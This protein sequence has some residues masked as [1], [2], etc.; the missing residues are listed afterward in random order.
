MKIAFKLPRGFVENL[1]AL[2]PW[3]F[4]GPYCH[5]ELVFDEEVR[6]DVPAGMIHPGDLGGSLCYSATSGAPRKGCGFIDIDLSDSSKWWVTELPCTLEQELTMLRY[7]IH[8]NGKPYDLRG[9]LGF[10]FPPVPDDRKAR[11]C[12]E[13]CTWIPQHACGY[14]KD[15]VPVRTTPNG[16]AYLV[17]RSISECGVLSA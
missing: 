14:F 15:A 5:C 10:V 2:Y 16:L 12:S 4:R 9:D 1:I 6:G 11:F 17:E 3:G 7:A 13:I 8:E